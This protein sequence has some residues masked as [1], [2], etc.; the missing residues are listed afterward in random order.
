MGIEVRELQDL[1]YCINCEH[2]LVANDGYRCGR[3][4][5]GLGFNLI[6]GGQESRLCKDERLGD[7]DD[8]CGYDAKYYVDK[9][10]AE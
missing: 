10:L 4:D 1:K 2:V 5:N 6:I 3:P 8:L 9:D 7:N